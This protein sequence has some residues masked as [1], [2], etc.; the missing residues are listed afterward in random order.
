MKILIYSSLAQ[1]TGSA[2]RANLIAE[3][4]KRRGMKVEYIKP[5]SKTLPYKIDLIISLPYYFFKAIFSN[6]N[7]VL[8]VKSY[9]NV[10]IP[11]ILKKL[12]G[13][14]IIID[15]DDLSFAYAKGLQRN[16]SQ[17]SEYFAL[18]LADLH[19]SHNQKLLNYLEKKLK[20]SSEKMYLL[21]QGIA[22]LFEK[23]NSKPTGGKKLLF[24]GHFD[25]ACD[26]E[27]ILRACQKVFVKMPEATLTLI[28]SGERKKEFLNL[29][30]DLGIDKKIFWTGLLSPEEV[31]R[32][33]L[34]SDVCLVFYKD[35]LA[36]Q[37]RV[38]LKLR[39]Y[40][41]LGK[42]V[43]CNNVGDLAE[44]RKFTYQTNSDLSE[45][46]KKII[47]VLSGYSDRREI[48]GTEYIKSNYSADKIA[49]NFIVKLQ[50]LT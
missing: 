45:F 7:Y 12:T 32:L 36:N 38:S 8:A 2:V 21:K 27:P 20:I 19:T 49:A 46:A 1:D 17:L 22:P 43:V 16:L 26:L 13:A 14:K 37:Y 41:A 40:L 39:E 48:R 11:I 5:L 23:K 31:A 44:F 10:I 6:T 28:G 25:N 29:A 47:K 18:E 34:L 15:T 9:P 33:I 24:V 4:L 35:N 3:S 42:R 50:K 30:R